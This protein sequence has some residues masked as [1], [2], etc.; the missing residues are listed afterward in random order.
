[1]LAGQSKSAITR[2]KRSLAVF[3]VVTL[4][5]ICALPPPGEWVRN[6]ALSHTTLVDV[7]KTR[8]AAIFGVVFASYWSS[9][10]GSAAVDFIPS[11]IIP[12]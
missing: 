9:L 2:Y 3:V 7:V 6:L 10:G 8:S 11:R 12:S 1:M 4:V 5:L